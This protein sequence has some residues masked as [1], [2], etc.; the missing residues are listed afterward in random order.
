MLVGGRTVNVKAR[1]VV[2]AAGAI[3]TPALLLR[4]RLNGEVGKHL[5]LHP[6]TG[7]L[8]LFDE[9]IRPWEGT[10]QARY[11]SEFRA[12]D[13]NYGPILETVPVTRAQPR[14]VPMGVERAP[15]SVHGGVRAR[16]TGS[17]PPRDRCSGRIRIGRDGNPRVPITRLAPAMRNASGGE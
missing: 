11:S 16:R 13:D 9:E 12:W 1:A 10:L 4:S 15:P 8:G 5:R 6:G 14:R 17:G 2:V 3:E 7:V